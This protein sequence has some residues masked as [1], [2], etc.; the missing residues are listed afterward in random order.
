MFTV[1]DDVEMVSGIE[2]E[3][4]AWWAGWNAA[5]DKVRNELLWAESDDDPDYIVM[6]LKKLEDI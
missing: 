4:E 6:R 1:P 3:N 5:I 2:A